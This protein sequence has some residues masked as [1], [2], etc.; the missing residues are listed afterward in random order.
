MPQP[1]LTLVAEHKIAAFIRPPKGGAVLEASGVIYK[2]NDYYV[3]FDN[4][5]RLARVRDGRP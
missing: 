3:V 2:G 5:R 1:V 4:I